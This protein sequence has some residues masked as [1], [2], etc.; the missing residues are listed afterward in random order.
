MNIHKCVAFFFFFLFS[1]RPRPGPVSA[2]RARRPERL[3]SPLR[4][5]SVRK[6]APFVGFL[7]SLGWRVKVSCQVEAA[8][9]GEDARRRWWQVNERT[10]T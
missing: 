8:R 4:H 6:R 5:A 1:P 2:V 7:F 10:T 3:R 9:S